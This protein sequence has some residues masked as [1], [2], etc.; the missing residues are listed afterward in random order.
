MY[1]LLYKSSAQA[2]NVVPYFEYP[3]L[4]SGTCGTKSSVKQKLNILAK[5]SGDPYTATALLFGVA[6]V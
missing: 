4:A 1:V 3:Q 2:K 6:K 5:F